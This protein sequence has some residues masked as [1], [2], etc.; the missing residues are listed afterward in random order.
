MSNKSDFDM[1]SLIS[2]DHKHLLWRDESGDEFL[3]LKYAEVYRYDKNTLRLHIWSSKK[4]SWLR[5]QGWILN[6]IE[7]DEPFTIIDV[8]VSKLEQLIE[9]GAFRRRPVLKGTW[10]KQKEKE[11]AHKIIPY[12]PSLRKTII[13]S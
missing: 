9:L 8:D 5:Q 7:L 3:L 11:L 10:L 2:S 1:R 4:R 12:N 6:E 13:K